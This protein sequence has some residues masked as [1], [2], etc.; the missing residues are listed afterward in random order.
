MITEHSDSVPRPLRGTAAPDTGDA[1]IIMGGPST[2]L[3]H[4]YCS[5]L[6]DHLAKPSQAA[7]R[8]GFALGKAA[9]DGGLEIFDLISL[10]HRA[11]AE[12]VMPEE[13]AEVQ[14]RSA[15]VIEDFLLEA[16]APFR[17]ASDGP[18]DTREGRR[19]MRS[20]HMAALARRNARLEEEVAD[21]QRAAAVMRD[22]K[23]H[24]F[25]L[26][27]NART[28]EANL[29]ELCAQ[30]LSAQEDERKRISR[31]L[32][33]EIGQALVAVKVTIATLKTRAASD[34]DSQRNAADAER[35]LA[36]AMETAHA[37]A[38]ELRPAMLDHLGLLSALRAQ[39]LVFARQT[40]IRAELV[41]HPVL[42]QLDERR[43]EVLFRVAQ[44]AL[45]N[46]S[47]HSGA[48]SAKIEFTAADD[49][50]QMEIS[51][52]GCA[53]SVEEQL[54]S[55][56]GGHYGLIGMQERV[57]HVNGSLAIESVSGNGTRVRAKIP[58][59]ERKSL[60]D[61]LAVDADRSSRPP[62]FSTTSLYE[63]NICSPR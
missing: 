12:G 46:V 27:Q 31:E 50:L 44:E 38:R 58:I 7:L 40:G 28:M 29:R 48:S 52:D 57:R 33:D 6:R 30:V 16:L 2:F 35:L 3:Y 47:K 54:A 32:Y 43:E 24:Y 26:Y 60:V 22:G 55:K 59:N 37:F 19:R 34:P 63:E 23:D 51:D 49:A 4:S 21:L 56:G 8:K 11:L 10:H 17:I 14:F 41:P 45:S 18:A 36:H 53:F 61:Q 39:I 5:A 42:A 13:L 1:G 25:Q 9:L 20:E 62:R 15:L